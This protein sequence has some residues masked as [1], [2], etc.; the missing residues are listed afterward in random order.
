MDEKVSAD[1]LITSEEASS[2]ATRAA[3][4]KRQTGVEKRIAMVG[5]KQEQN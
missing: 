5:L 2:A 4:A 3:K 1:R